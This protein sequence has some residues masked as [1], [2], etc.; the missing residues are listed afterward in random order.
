MSQAP[1]LAP[2]ADSS[3]AELVD[4]RDYNTSV[5]SVQEEV[6]VRRDDGTEETQQVERRVVEV[7]SGI[8]YKDAQGNF[9]PSNPHWE[10]TPE[11]FVLR[12]CAYGLSAGKTLAHPIT[13]T[14]RGDQLRFRPAFLKASSGSTAKV[15]ASVDTSVTGIVDPEDPRRLVFPGAFGGLG[16]LEILAKKGS[17]H[18]NVILNTKPTTRLDSKAEDSRLSL[19]TELSLDEFLAEDGAEVRF[20]SSVIRGI[21]SNLEVAPSKDS[22]IRF[23]K[24]ESDGGG[25]PKDVL[26]HFFAESP[27]YSAAD[28]EP[29]ALVGE[30]AERGL[31]RDA[32][33]NATYLVE[34][35]PLA[36]LDQADYPLIWDFQSVSGNYTPGDPWIPAVTYQVTAD[37]YVSSGTLQ[38]LPGTVV[39]LNPNVSIYASG[40]AIH[41]KGEPYDYI[42]FTKTRD[43]TCGERITGR[44]DSAYMCA[45][46]LMS[47]S[48]AN[49]VVQYCKMGYGYFGVICS[50]S[51]GED[52][53]I[54]HNI[55]RGQNVLWMGI[56]V[57]SGANTSCH[58]NLIT[59]STWL[60]IQY[61][62]SGS[63]E[64]D[65]TNNT[66]NGANVGIQLNYSTFRDVT[67]NLLTNCYF[68]GID[69]TTSTVNVLDHNGFWMVGTPVSGGGMGPNNIDLPDP[70]NPYDPCS[71]GEFYLD[72]IAGEGA[73]LRDRPGGRTAEAA[74]LLGQQFTV[75]KPNVAPAL[76]TSDATWSKIATDTGTVD[77]GYHHNRVDRLL[78]NQ[79]TVVQNA[80]LILE[81]GAVVA[82][83]GYG[84]ELHIG[85]QGRLLSVGNGQGGQEILFAS[86]RSVSMLMDAS[87][88]PPQL[89]SQKPNEYQVG[90]WLEWNSSFASEVRD[91]NF[92]GL[93]TGV[94]TE[95][96]TVAPLWG[97]RFFCCKGSGVCVTGS[98]LPDVRN[99]LFAD[100]GN[101]ITVDSYSADAVTLLDL[102]TLDRCN[103]GVWIWGGGVAEEYPLVYVLNS[104][105]TFNSVYGIGYDPDYGFR[106]SIDHCGYWGN[107]QDL[108]PPLGQHETN[109]VPITSAPYD[110]SGGPYGRWFLDQSGAAVNAAWHDPASAGLGPHTT[111]VDGRLDDHFA[112]IGYH[113][114]SPQ[115]PGGG[116]DAPWVTIVAPSSGA[117]LEGVPTVT[118]NAGDNLGVSEV[119]IFRDG[120]LVATAEP[121]PENAGTF[122]ASWATNRMTNGPGALQ[123]V[124]V[125]YDGNAG[126][127]PVVPVSIDNLIT[128]LT[129]DRSGLNPAAGERLTVT[130]VLSESAPWTLGIWDWSVA[131]PDEELLVV[132]A[133]SGSGTYV[134]A[135]WDGKDG[136]GQIVPDAPYTYRL[137]AGTESQTADGPAA[138]YTVEDDEVQAVLFAPWDDVLA[139]ARRVFRFIEEDLRSHGVTTKSYLL[140]DASW[141]AFV[142]Q[143]RNNPNCYVFIYNGHSAKWMPQHE[144]SGMSFW[145]WDRGKLQRVFDR[146]ETCGDPS[147]PYTV[148]KLGIFGANKMKLVY[149]DSCELGTEWPETSMWWPNPLAI[150]FGTHSGAGDQSY[151][152][153]EGTVPMSSMGF[154]NTFFHFLV[155]ERRSVAD[156]M[157]RTIDEAYS[158]RRGFCDRVRVWGDHPTACFIPPLP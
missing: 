17:L 25:N 110:P 27:V 158:T 15:I 145:A 8:C 156:A 87:F 109:R 143:V 73:E 58:N 41:A 141:Q 84:R 20:G 19:Y 26:H 122:T 119:L 60:G 79:N 134:L 78:D 74:G 39:K 135:D 92:R 56:K 6:K 69:V 43:D 9:Q 42:V 97:N 151:I 61:Y 70:K 131:D 29:A 103:C 133:G 85:G 124:A 104:L 127:S 4:R 152:G 118:V 101:G 105:L 130:A 21:G 54:A 48:P 3:T 100:C 28:G 23:Y 18:Q 2:A 132:E 72:N 71:V 10:P 38:I 40:G 7:G 88:M 66:V 62:S 65:I 138:S 142:Y 64:T 1:A 52:N 148:E 140:Q 63:S 108:Q 5:W 67:D 137:H 33:T 16:D 57:G 47:G 45:I 76:I 37:L 136:A 31:F 139:H 55:I 13:Y 49:S 14:T 120:R 149:M 106:Y 68:S 77:I 94:R 35:V 12:Q 50:R 36:F 99:S 75:N 150:M 123:A 89:P 113:Y 32:A 116:P 112:D 11:G 121:D 153:Y 96:R 128:C 155:R 98:A 34:S 154:T 53:P 146:D 95:L 93:N 125:D 107:G 91:T 51:L 102:N 86:K 144:L 90:I 117:T 111:A 126:A 129:S 59:D 46:Y 44:A 22:P 81:P 115:P 30:R 83:H 157:R 147:Y 114:P 80:A 82:I 24:T